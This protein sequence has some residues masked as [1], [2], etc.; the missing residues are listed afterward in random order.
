MS[1][2]PLS[3]GSKA[4]LVQ[5]VADSLPLLV[6][7][8][9]T[10]KRATYFNKPWLAFTG[11]SLDAEIGDGWADGVHPLDLQQCLDTYVRAFD[12][13]EPFTMDY[14]LRRH[15][16]EYRWVLDNAAPLFD[17]DG[18]FA[19]Y[20]GACFDVTEFR[21]AEAERTSA[22]ESLRRKERELH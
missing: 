17:A 9:G 2:G 18:S 22:E 4:E 14:R 12:R 6:W 8:A 7:I 10:D 19:G 5:L 1:A 21:R 16:G 11:R 13:R 15:D 20:I 3:H